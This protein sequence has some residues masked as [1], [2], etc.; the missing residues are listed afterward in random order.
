MI[1]MG[2]LA[3]AVKI[4]ILRTLKIN[5]R[6]NYS[7]KVIKPQLEASPWERKK[8]EHTSNVP[9]FGAREYPRD[10]FLSHA[11]GTRIL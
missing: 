3:K 7:G 4:N 5:Q 6:L 10:L 1:A 2:T 9:A 8:L 11:L